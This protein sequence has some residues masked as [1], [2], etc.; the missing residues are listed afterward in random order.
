M[1]A[2]QD[3]VWIE[4]GSFLMGSEHGYPEEGPVREVA[5]DG[6]WMQ[7]T[8]VTNAQYGRCVAD[9]AC[10]PPQAE[11]WDASALAEHPVSHVDW[12]QANAYA[13]WAGGRLPTEAEWEKACRSDDGR[14]Y[15]W[16]DGPPTPELA[17]FANNIGETLPVGSLPDGASPYGI[18]DL[19]GN[20]WEWTSSL[21]RAYPYAAA[22]GR[23]DAE[24]EDKR[25]ARGGSFYYTQYQLRCT[26][27]SGFDPSTANPNFGLRVVVAPNAE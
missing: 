23:E 25:A 8:E 22:D 10:T 26:S 15:P 24:A 9:G 18:L 16:G 12:E 5:V 14:L 19:S 2:V 4:G 6:F 21:E 1:R 3:M 20:V 11:G 13:R 7:Q 27:R 17:N